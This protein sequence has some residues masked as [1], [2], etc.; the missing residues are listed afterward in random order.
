M[1]QKVQKSHC[2]ANETNSVLHRPVLF[3]FFTFCTRVWL[4]NNVVTVSGEEQMDSNLYLQMYPIYPKL[5]SH[6]G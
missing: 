2:P 5:P 3:F 1:R 4:I 6:P